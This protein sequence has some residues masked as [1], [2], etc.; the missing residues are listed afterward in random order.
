MGKLAIVFPGQG[1]QSVGMG[2]SLSQSSSAAADAFARIDAAA[3]RSLSQLCFEGPEAELKRTINT[4]PTILA[5]SLAAWSAYQSAG[6][7]KPDV[8]AGHSLGEITALCVAGVL[9]LEDAV[10]LVEK[11]AALM[12][13][14]PAGAMSAVLGMDREKLEATLADVSSALSGEGKTGNDT[15]VVIANYNTRDQLVI[16]GNPDAVARANAMIKERGGKAIP[17]PVGGAFHSPLMTD[18]A[19]EFGAALESKTF[20]DAD[21]PVVQNV[22]A[23]EA[24][25]AA[26]LKSNLAL[27][28]RNA[29]RWTEIVERMAAMGVDTIVEIGP[30]KVLTGLV[31]KIDKNIRIYNINDE[32]SLKETLAAISAATV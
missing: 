11:R 6:G 20:N 27:Q 5:A 9:T 30:G 22:N 29:V 3:G 31:K 23:S 32:T 28:M 17:L 26:T 25:D 14:C 12:E 2:Q 4:Q 8:V 7:S 16:S 10:K 24:T 18:A 19:T 1:S 15:V 13:S 21:F